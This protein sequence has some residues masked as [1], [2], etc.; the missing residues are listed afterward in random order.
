VKEVA[1]RSPRDARANGIGMVYQQFTL[2][3]CLTG[4]EN[5]VISRADAPA[6]HRLGERE[7]APRRLHG[8]RCRSA[9]R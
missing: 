8:S 7:E 1:I 2:V 4:A 9:C 5:L 3:P 6:G